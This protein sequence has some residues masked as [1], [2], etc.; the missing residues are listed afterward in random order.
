MGVIES[1]GLWKQDLQS[2]AAFNVEKLIR[3][4]EMCI[5]VFA[6][7]DIPV[8]FVLPAVWK[9]HCGLIGASDGECVSKAIE[10]YPTSDQYIYRKTPKGRRV[11]AYDG[12]SDALL[13]AYWRSCQ[14]SESL[15]LKHQNTIVAKEKKAAKKKVERA[16]RE[17]AA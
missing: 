5:T 11:R 15:E 10:L 17:L 8:E 14:T 2:G 6:L 3:H 9:S 16:K 1:V 13:I 4:Q 7:L 12:V